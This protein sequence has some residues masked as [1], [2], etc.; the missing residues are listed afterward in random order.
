MIKF[1]LQFRFKLDLCTCLKLKFDSLNTYSTP[2][3]Y[4]IDPSNVLDD[5]FGLKFVIVACAQV[6]F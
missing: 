3:R 1:F 4:L 2:V 5:M 6:K